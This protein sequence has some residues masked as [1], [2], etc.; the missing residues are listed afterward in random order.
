[1]T[2]RADPKVDVFNADI[3]RNGGYLYSTNA[4][5]SS[6]LAHGRL[7]EAVLALGDYQDQTVLDIGCGDGTYTIELYDRARP[8]AVTGVDMAALAV[9]AARRRAGR[10]AI[11]FAVAS[12]YQLPFA[13]DRF[14][15]AVLRAVLHHMDR[16][17]T[18]LREALRVARRIVV[19][20]PNGYNPVLKILEK[21]SA[22]HIEHGEKSYA[23][24]RLRHWVR[25]GG[26]EITRK[27][28]VGLVPCFCPDWLA[29][30]A[31]AV[32]PVGERVPLVNALGC[33]CYVFVARR[34]A[35]ASVREVAA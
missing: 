24:A 32:E 19:V 29:R 15:W 16:P 9:A 27:H 13:E 11:T 3:L 5:L 10:R 28:F 1:M 6:R 18:A 25:A 20:E 33:A 14:D 12:A 35:A 34:H 30:L 7:T 8:A 23:P 17:L 31:K 4:R 21:Y 22:Y 26:G 2:T